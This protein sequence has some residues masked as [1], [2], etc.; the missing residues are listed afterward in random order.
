MI[1]VPAGGF[2]EPAWRCSRA[3][4]AVPGGQAALLIVGE[5]G[6]AGGQAAGSA[7]IRASA[8]M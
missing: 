1:A 8:V 3:T 4:L 5:V 7:R 6:G 2:P